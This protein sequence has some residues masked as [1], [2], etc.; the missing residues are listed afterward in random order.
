MRRNQVQSWQAQQWQHALQ[1]YQ[2]QQATARGI[3]AQTTRQRLQQV[4]AA[5]HPLL[6]R[7]MF[8]V[9]DISNMFSLMEPRLL[10]ILHQAMFMEGELQKLEWHWKYK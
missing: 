9:K 2:Q 4:Q 6:S 5:P 10:C 7:N 8:D 3:A 1:K